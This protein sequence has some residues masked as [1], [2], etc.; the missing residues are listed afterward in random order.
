MKKLFKRY[1]Q[2]L[3]GLAVGIILIGAGLGMV[4]ATG[5]LDDDSGEIENIAP[6]ALSVTDEEARAAVRIYPAT[7]DE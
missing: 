1:G 2:L 5:G 6:G 3:A 4:A 7:I